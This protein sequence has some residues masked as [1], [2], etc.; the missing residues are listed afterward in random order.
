MGGAAAS[1][2]Q[3]QKLQMLRRE[4]EENLLGNFFFEIAQERGGEEL[5][6][7]NC[8]EIAQERGGGGG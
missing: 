5:L 6:R 3:L 1:R 4:G 2:C 8:S 7:R